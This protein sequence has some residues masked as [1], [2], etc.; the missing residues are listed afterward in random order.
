MLFCCII[1][2]F[3]ATGE[4]FFCVMI[5]KR[6]KHLFDI[7]YRATPNN[8]VLILARKNSFVTHYAYNELL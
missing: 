5:S 3:V 2:S 4:Y 1:T 8:D 6:H 7:S